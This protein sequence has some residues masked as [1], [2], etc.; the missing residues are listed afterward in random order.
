MNFPFTQTQFFGVFTAYNNSVWPAQ[1]LFYLL[2][3]LVLIRIFQ[4]TGNSS[5]SISGILAFFW[6]WIGVV[7]NW[8][9]FVSIN[10][11]AKLFGLLFVIQ[12][13]LFIYAGIIRKS[14]IFSYSRNLKSDTGIFLVIFG[15]V[16]Y[17]LLGTLFQHVFPAS[18]TFGLPCPTTIF[19]L[20]VLLMTI[21][22]PK[23]LF[24]IPA[25]WS[26]I[27]F[28]AAVKFGVYEDVSLLLAGIGTIFLIYLKPG[29]PHK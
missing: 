25:I 16:L 3:A 26:L 4:K 27:G 13:L 24:L 20:G 19:T 9:Y 12:G 5:V 29:Y 6:I 10:P 11:A 15:T 18:P 14:L 7:Y 28:T 8:I 17:P 21:N 1:V 23:Y 22:A 2:A